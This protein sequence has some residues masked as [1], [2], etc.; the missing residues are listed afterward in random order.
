MQI[1]A[2]PVTHGNARMKAARRDG[3]DLNF[4]NNLMNIKH[5]VMQQTKREES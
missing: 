2:D 4:L 1:T 5:S 3:T